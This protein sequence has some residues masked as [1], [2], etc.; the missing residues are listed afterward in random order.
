MPRRK[1]GHMVGTCPP[2]PQNKCR[3]CKLGRL[4]PVH[5]GDIEKPSNLKKGKLKHLARRR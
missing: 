3:M 1:Y 5:K 2:T 4:C